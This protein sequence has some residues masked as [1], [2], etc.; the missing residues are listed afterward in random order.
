MQQMNYNETNGIIIGP[1]FSRIFAELILQS[2]DRSVCI[3]LQHGP[4]GC[5]HKTHYEIFRFVDDYF[6]FYNDEKVK[7]EIVQVLQLKLKDYKLYL[8]KSKAVGYEKPI[9]TNISMAKHR[10]ERLL[11]EKLAYKI[12]LAET[13]KTATGPANG[14]GSE[15]TGSIRI[16]SNALITQFKTIIKEYSVD[17]KDTLN[18][19]LSIVEGRSARILR[20]HRSIKRDANSEKQ[21]GQAIQEICEFTFFIYSV[22]PRANTTIRLCRILSL[23]TAFLKEPGVNADIKHS[24]FKVV[25]DNISLILGKNA[26]SEHTPV[27]TVYLLIALS[28]LGKNYWLGL[29]ILCSYFRIPFDKSTG[30]VK[31]TSALNY[32]SLVVL[33]FYIKNRKEYAQLRSAIETAIKERFH[34]KKEHAPQ[35]NRTHPS[36]FRQLGMSLSK[37]GSEGRSLEVIRG[38]E[39]GLVLKRQHLMI[40]CLPL[41]L[42]L[43]YLQRL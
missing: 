26:N 36:A 4:L 42:L 16:D 20:E 7:E 1:E 22:S 21:L 11:N 43:V 29:E 2:V 28:E 23:F 32:I 17:Y 5:S 33:L 18:Y 12:G 34:K 8:N 40:F 25:F 37:E 15:K 9:I 39:H 6:V 31:I 24:V 27:E 13:N 35:R 3:E 19:A 38:N 14:K 41:T 10:I 30:T